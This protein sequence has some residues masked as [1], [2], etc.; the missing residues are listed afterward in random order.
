VY[1][2]RDVDNNAIAGLETYG[3]AV[4]VTAVALTNV[5]SGD[6]LKVKITVTHQGDAAT[7]AFVLT[8]WRTKP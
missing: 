8:G 6:A 7:D 4:A 2:I 1:G 3:V 5:P